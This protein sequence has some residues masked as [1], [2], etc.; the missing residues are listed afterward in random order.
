MSY[1]GI[2]SPDSEVMFRT[3]ESLATRGSFAVT[4]ELA[5]K[6]FGLARGKDGNLYSIFG[7]LEAIAT[8]PIYKIAQLINITKWYQN[9][10]RFVPISHHV[11]DGLLNFVRDDI[12]QD[13]YPHALRFFVCLFN[14][15][16]S[17]MCVI[18][19]FLLVKALTQSDVSAVFTTILFAFGTLIFPYS[20]T[21]FSEPMATFF[22]MLSL[23]LLVLNDINKK[24]LR[25]KYYYLITSGIF[26]GLATATHITAILFIPFFC[27]YGVYSSHNKMELTIKRVVIFSSIFMLGVGLILILV[28]YYNLKRLSA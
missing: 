25:Y 24:Y 19:F 22:V 16:I 5:W 11:E 12:P 7:P 13:L 27:I 21:F 4:E 9:N 6:E 2:R 28:G 10:S 1:G 8:T 26:L 18:L 3:I 20:G 15:L 17:S 23:Y 14:I